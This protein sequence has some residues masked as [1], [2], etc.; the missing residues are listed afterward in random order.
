MKRI[1]PLIIVLIT[2]SLIG[3]IYLQYS[4]FQNLLIV[5]EEQLFERVVKAMQQVANDVSL[6]S[7]RMPLLRRQRKSHLSLN[8]DLIPSDLM[9]TAMISDRFTQ[10]EIKEKLEAALAAHQVPKTNFGFAVTNNLNLINYEMQSPNFLVLLEDTVNNHTFNYRIDPPAD[11]WAEGITPYEHIVLI[12]PNYRRLIIQQSYWELVGAVVFTLFIMFAFFVTVRTMINQRNLNAIKTDFINNMTHEFK[13]P[14]ATIGLAVDALNNEKVLASPEK[15]QYFRGIIKDENKRMNKHVET[16][17]EAA[18]FERQELNLSLAACSGHA[19]LHH[20]VNNCEL[21][22]KE[23]NGQIRLHFDAK[24]DTILADE[25]HFANLINNLLDNAMK[26]AKDQPD[27]TITTS[28]YAKYFV[29]KIEDK[30]I[31]MSRETVKRI[32]EKFYRAPTGNVHNVKGFGL[33]MSYVKTI[34]DAHRGR[35]KVDSVLGKGSTFT[36]E[37]PLAKAER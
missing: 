29:V 11:S 8:H 16:I 6:S 35:V 31:G 25:N 22:L 5:K 34:I 26:Y 12:I 13:T 14:L 21:M 27:I 18:A 3:I 24:A 19:M 32:F 36:V 2:V 7:N 37:V 10:F 20:A 33:G 9:Q 28:N 17:L 4:R 15:M 1:V 30:G 23:K